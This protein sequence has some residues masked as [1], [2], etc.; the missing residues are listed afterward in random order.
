MITNENFIK[1][2]LQFPETAPAT[3][4]EIISFKVKNKIFVT[5]NIKESRCCIKLSEVEQ[6]LFC[7]IDKNIIFPVPNKWGKHGWTLVKLNLVTEELLIEIL[8]AAYCCV[9]P[10]KLSAPYLKQIDSV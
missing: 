6:T 9:A 10:P 1:Y 2:P 8:T 4:F 3:Q 7:M 5:H